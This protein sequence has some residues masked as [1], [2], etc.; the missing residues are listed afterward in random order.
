MEY[1]KYFKKTH[2]QSVTA[3]IGSF[4]TIENFIE[5]LTS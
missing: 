3:S 4:Q 1:F 2:Q 5:A